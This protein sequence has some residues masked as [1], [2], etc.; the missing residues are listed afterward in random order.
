MTQVAALLRPRPRDAEITTSQKS[1]I[2]FMPLVDWYK[3][4]KENSVS[5]TIYNQGITRDTIK[6]KVSLA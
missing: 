4:G 6:V 2:G 3:I 5:V 1:K